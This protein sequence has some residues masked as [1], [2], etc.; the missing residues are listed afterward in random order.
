MNTFWVGSEACWKK[1]SI[2]CWQRKESEW[3]EIQS[4]NDDV[5][6][7]AVWIPIRRNS[8]H[9]PSVKDG[10]VWHM[11]GVLVRPQEA[12]IV[13]P[14]L[15]TVTRVDQDFGENSI[16][17]FDHMELKWMVEMCR[18]NGSMDYITRTKNMGNFAGLPSAGTITPTCKIRRWRKAKVI[19][20]PL[21]HVTSVV[22]MPQDTTSKRKLSVDFLD[23]LEN[24]SY[25][26]ALFFHVEEGWRK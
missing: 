22:N 15:L 7:F 18:P 20:K 14:C 2:T 23:Y 16:F 5:Y 21:I 9:G 3:E 6:K 1:G 12:R 17:D 11:Q 13:I 24:C 26:S 10:K 19:D 25:S 8:G 4:S